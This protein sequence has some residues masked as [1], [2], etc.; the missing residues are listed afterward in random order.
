MFDMSMIYKCVLCTLLSAAGAALPSTA[1]VRIS[2]SG[3]IEAEMPSFMG[4]PTAYVVQNA[5]D[6]TIE[7]TSS[8]G[9]VTWSRF[10]NLGAAY[11]EVVTDVEIH[12]RVHMLRPGTADMGYV[13]EE[14]GKNP[15]YFWVVNYEGHRYSVSSLHVDVEGSDCG[16]TR[17]EATGNAGPI[18][19]YG[20]SGRSDVLDREMQLTYNTLVYDSGSEA[21]NQTAV[22]EKIE[23]IDGSFGAPAPLCD[24]RFTLSPDR[25]TR[26]WY[27]SVGDCESDSY[28]AV[29]VDAH[30]TAEQ[31]EVSS[32]NEQK[33]EGTE[34]ALGG[35]APCEITFKAAVS[36]AAIYRRWEISTSPDFEDVEL[37]F[38]QTEFTHVFSDAGSRYVRFTA[39]NAAAT[40]LFT[41][42][43]YQVNIG[44]S[45][46]LCPNAFSPGASEGVNDE[47]KV[48]YRSIVSFDC[49]IFNRWGQK[50]ATLTDPSQGW[51]GKHGGKVVPSGVYFY[52][53]KARGADGKD[54]K[55][56]GDIN[57]INSRKGNAGTTAPVE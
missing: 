45:R 11:A 47:W 6:A 24:T 53:I 12:G 2:G 34:G 19:C 26:T 22:T 21:Y 46:L 36:D 3:V 13:I 27:P 29:A 25:F 18:T 38:D 14:T 52:V 49:Q 17:I 28:T 56:S 8:G 43:T 50:L 51:D 7:Y 31:V 32:D 54:Y 35:S 9:Q 30:T 37:T 10:S 39:D 1:Q 40:C 33:T 44:E 5:A 48:S 15:L 57:V 55:L 16:R 23:A 4:Y 42:E 20:I 41:G